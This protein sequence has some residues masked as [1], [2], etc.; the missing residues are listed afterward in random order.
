MPATSSTYSTSHVLAKGDQ[1]SAAQ[2]SAGAVGASPSV[3]TRNNLPLP[4]KTPSQ[5]RAE[6]FALKSVVNRLLP[7]SRT[8]KCMRW[9]VPGLDVKLKKGVESNRAYYH[10]LQVCASVW[11]CPVCAAK[12][13]ERRRAELQSAMAIAKAKGW[14]VFLVTLTVP[15]GLGDDLREML[16]KLKRA[17]DKLTS[18]RAGV[19]FRQSIGLQGTVRATE[20]TDGQ[21]GFHPHFHYLYFCAP[22]ES[23][24]P[25]EIQWKL[26]PLWQQCCVK[27]GL[28]CPSDRHGCRVDDGNRAADYVAKGSWGLDSE[29]TKGHLKR[30]RSTKGCSM[31][32]HLRAVLADP[33]D[34]RSAARFATF[35]EAFTGRRQLVWSKGLKA[36]LA[37]V[38]KDD[39]ELVLEE[40]EDKTIVLAQFSDSE[41]RQVYRTRSEAFLLD[42]AEKTPESIP[43]FL[44][45]LFDG[46][47]DPL[48]IMESHASHY[49]LPPPKP[50]GGARAACGTET[51]PGDGALPVT[52][53]VLFP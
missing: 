15:H 34:K 53:G 31:M 13:S 8:S 16:D 20:V 30:S 43:V 19:A 29:M 44:M 37:V 52:S 14:Q 41:W 7:E 38:D 45:L 6:R 1:A 32:D 48:E 17:A 50:G 47:V 18:T 51:P 33:S 22:G 21:N 27:A 2:A 35:V 4:P 24:S 25:L 46:V 23:L 36:A 11:A 28:P 9:R 49:G 40:I 5:A 12:I 10:G 42:L 39:E 3:Y 26:S